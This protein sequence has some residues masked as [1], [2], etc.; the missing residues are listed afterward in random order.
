VFP[1]GWHDVCEGLRG[2][3]VAPVAEVTSAPSALEHEV[4]ED[5]PGN[6]DCHWELFSP[7]L[8]VSAVNS[9]RRFTNV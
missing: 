6:A 8:R 4:P 7:R 9:I 5:F 3:R 2:L 1:R